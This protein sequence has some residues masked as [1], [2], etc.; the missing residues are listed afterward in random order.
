MLQVEALSSILGVEA[1]KL[2]EILNDAIATQG[3]YQTEFKSYGKRLTAQKKEDI[4]ALG[5][6]GLEFQSP[7]IECIQ[8]ALLHL[9]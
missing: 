7:V 2:A 1:S 3:S 8:Q 4:E 6:P 9:S 5:L